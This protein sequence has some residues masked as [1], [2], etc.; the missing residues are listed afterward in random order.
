[1]DLTTGKIEPVIQ[2][3]DAHQRNLIMA[4]DFS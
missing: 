4:I 1:M 3:A 2:T